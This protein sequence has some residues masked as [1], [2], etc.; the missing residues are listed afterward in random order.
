MIIKELFN[1]LQ[2]DEELLSVSNKTLT[3]EF[4]ELEQSEAQKT[5]QILLRDVRFTKFSGGVVT[6]KI[7]GLEKHT[8]YMDYL[9]FCNQRAA[10]YSLFIITLNYLL[11]RLQKGETQ[12]LVKI[13]QLFLVLLQEDKESILS[14]YTDHKELFQECSEIRDKV[15]LILYEKKID[16]DVE[17]VKKN[18]SDLNILLSHQKN[19][20][21]IVGLFRQCIGDTE[22]FAALILWLLDQKV[23]IRKILQTH[24]LH[25]FLKYHL[26]SL[27][28][29]NNEVR[30]LYA[31]LH[32]FPNAAPLIEAVKKTASDERG[33]QQYSLTGLV[34]Q[35]QLQ[36]FSLQ[37]SSSEFSQIPENFLNLYQLFG[38]PFL[39]EAAVTVDEHTNPQWL[40]TLSLTLNNPKT[41]REQIS[42]L[43]H[44]IACEY[45]PPV[46]ESLADLINDTTAQELLFNNEGTALYLIPYKPTLFD[47][48]HEKNME[49]LIQ[50]I[51][52]KHDTDPEIIYQLAALFVAFSRR[53]HSATQLVF[54]ALIDILIQHPQ[55]LED[56]ELIK[57][58]KKYPDSDRLL[59][60][61]YEVIAKKFNDCMLEQT[62][63]SSFSTHNYQVIEDKWL[64]ASRKFAALA[65]IKPQTKFNLGHKYAFQAKIAEIVFIHNKEHFNLDSFIEALSLPPAS[66]E[67]VSEYERLLI[68]I[69]ATID[70]EVLRKQIID[71]L[72]AHPI[73]RFDWM[74]KEYEDKTIFFKAAKYGNLGLIKMLESNV[75]SELLNQGIIAAAK[76]NQWEAVAYLVRLDNAV[77]NEEELE[78][79]V[80]LAAEEGQVDIIEYLYNS[81]DYIPSPSEIFTIL[82]RAIANKHLNVVDYFYRSSFDFPKQSK[83][84]SLFNLAIDKG[85]L[86]V[87]SFIAIA[88]KN[89]P[90]LST[91]EK[92]FEYSAVN[93]KLQ[94]M[95]MLCNLSHNAPRPVVIQRAFVKACQLGHLPVVEYLYTAS[96]KL[97]SE[98]TF[99]NALEQAIINGHLEL[100]TYFYNSSTNRPDQSMSNRGI[101]S[102]AKAGKLSLIEYFCSLTTFNKPNQRAIAQALE[103]AINNNHIIVFTTLCGNQTNPPSKSSIRESLL[104]A[105]KKGNK[106]VIDYLCK[107]KMEAL[108]QGTIEKVFLLAVKFY[109]PEIVRYL[110]NVSKNA[111]EKEA[112]RSAYHKAA[113][114]GQTKIANYLGERLQSKQQ[115]K[116]ELV[117]SDTSL[118]TP[119]IAH[120]LFKVSKESQTDGTYV[121]EKVLKC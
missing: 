111:P 106:E 37:F 9:Q 55:F 41:S 21:G 19:P 45:S 14:F 88:E 99:K 66:P 30:R 95:K 53:K 102:A 94:I 43:I 89:S 56:D 103:Q 16:E 86:D 2:G 24:I 33:F 25:D 116:M 98:P 90:T 72:E 13:N 113:A 12:F 75:N 36:E 91:I 82:E 74:Q 10:E 6:E 109:Q 80:L 110:C 38:L 15:G 40:E 39:I 81:Y 117:I 68:E 108:D 42:A 120:G 11:S 46:L 112:M 70:D 62:A 35:D 44:Y 1:W 26:F 92:A 101:I 64:D 52:L 96:R 78:N 60:Q 20:L 97:I 59:S 115:D 34:S 8:L 84:N 57:Q 121:V 77:L 31:L 4:L 119:L 71:K 67:V 3:R 23:S 51:S 87:V 29:T 48:I 27:N 93:L 58:L 76:N 100:V 28:D 118:S 65:L 22:Q 73:E 54:E 49:E 105:V 63:E 114:S 7:N 5:Y 61:R 18:L 17:T 104:F 47:V 85:A 83:I 69:L 107:N 50:K 79:L 32:R